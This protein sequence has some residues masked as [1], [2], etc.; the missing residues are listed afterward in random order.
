LRWPLEDVAAA[1][2]TVDVAAAAAA[3]GA[4]VDVAAAGV[5][6]G[7]AV[8]HVVVGEP[9]GLTEVGTE[10]DVAMV[11]AV[12]AEARRNPAIASASFLTR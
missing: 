6:A 2:A 11:V 3:A 9:V 1:G 8:E 5:A 10:A 12:V 4:A 7:A